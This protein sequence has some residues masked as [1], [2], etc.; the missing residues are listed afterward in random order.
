MIFLE[1]LGVFVLVF[2]T[3]CVGGI[4]CGLIE[5]HTRLNRIENAIKRR[6]L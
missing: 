2:L 3:V 4:L 6:D 5:T 1:I